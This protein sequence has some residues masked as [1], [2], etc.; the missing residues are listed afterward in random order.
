ML[1]PLPVG[2]SL[3]MQIDFYQLSRDPI[4]RVVPLLAD[5]ALQS[6]ARVVVVCGGAARRETLSQHLWARE[7]TFLAHGEAG[8]P[9]AA[10]QPILLAEGCEAANGASFAVIADGKWRDDAE[11]F[12]RAI[13][14][15]AT[16]QLESARG[17]WKTLK[18]AGQALRFF[19][20]DGRGR[21]KQEG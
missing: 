19:A 21:W 18:G 16:D 14:L 11:R 8:E 13:L 10:L 5:K 7:E 9:H 15:F 4:E 6:G 3:T 1:G 12:E 17:L 20:Q 2:Q